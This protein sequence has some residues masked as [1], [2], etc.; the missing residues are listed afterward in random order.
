[1][2]GKK[3]ESKEFTC[4]GANSVPA[5][6]AGLWG[7]PGYRVRVRARRSACPPGPPLLPSPR[8]QVHER[9]QSPDGYELNFATNTLGSFALTLALEP[10]LKRS[11]P[12]KVSGRRVAG[13][14][15]T[16]A[17]WAGAFPRELE[18]PGGRPATMHAAR[19]N[20]GRPSSQASRRGSPASL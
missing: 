11:A 18:M 4:K 13:G 2:T 17:S 15:P 8:L 1:M 3:P 14:A 16:A 10:V 5:R 7:G 20:C 9:Q 19:S 6:G 12:A